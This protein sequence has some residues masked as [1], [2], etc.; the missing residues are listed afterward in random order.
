M[1]KPSIEQLFTYHPPFGS[2]PQRYQAIRD[3][4]RAFA[5]LVND[6]CPSSREASLAITAIQQATMWANASIAVNETQPAEPV[7]Q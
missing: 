3:M 5:Q 4:A 7:T 1:S 2:Q 6:S